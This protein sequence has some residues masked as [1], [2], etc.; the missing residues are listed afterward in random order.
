MKLNY[1]ED[2]DG[3]RAIAVLSVV[4]NHAGISLF[5]GGFIGVDVFFVISGYL[6]TTIIVRE[7]HANEFF[8]ARFYERRI[9]R[10]FPALF[11]VLTFTTLICAVIYDSTKFMTFGKS[12]I[13]TTFFVSNINFWQESGYFDISSQLKPLLHTWSLAVEEQFY[14]FFPLLMLLLNRYVR[15]AMPFILSIL[16]V[17]SLGLAMYQVSTD[18]A[19]A[20]YLPQG[21]AWELLAGALV[22]LNISTVSIKRGFSNILEI[23]GIL[24]ILIPVFVY[25]ESTQFPGLS[26]VPP[27]LGTALIILC[28]NQEKSLIGKILSLPALV[29]VGKISYSLYLWHWPLLIFGKYYAIRPLTGLETALELILIFILSSLSW[30]YVE[31]PFR[32]RSFLKTRQ[33]FAF[34]TGVM[35]MALLVG[36]AIYMKS[37]FPSREMTS[38][39]MDRDKKNDRWDFK[40]CNVNYIDNPKTIP[41]CELGVNARK[42][43]FLVW[44]DSHAPTVGK[45]INISATSSEFSGVLTYAAGCP[46]LLGMIPNPQ[47]GDVHCIDYNNMVFTYLQEHPEITTIILSSRW[48]TWVEGS[49]YKQEE[50]QDLFLMDGLEL[51]NQ[52][53]SDKVSLF[54]LG[55]ERTIEA[56]QA[57]N[58]DVFIVAPMPEIGYDVP[59]A[60]FIAS[61]TGRDLNEIIAPSTDEYLSRNKKTF[62]ILRPLADQYQI[63]IV[64]PWRILCTEV[65]CRVAVDEFPLYRDDD[66]LSTFGSEMIASAFDVIFGS[67]EQMEK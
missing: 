45:A 6:I 3:L 58:H 21:R 17:I 19:A 61:R 43:S 65:R 49:R 8:L 52:N 40:E 32:S 48:T 26:A 30:R 42:P 44:G 9:R 34:A 66:H 50:G 16:A 10:I 36:T 54:T 57:S 46:P 41:V 2:I 22:A 53:E 33:I 4:L 28:G 1:R 15:R 31:T 7:L 56:L 59:S 12:L 25:S 24:M 20:F 13:A 35:G 37:G 29:F 23:F 39:E 51:N 60:Y 11:T 47:V 63:Q 18:P 64:E 55:L 62:E 67:M 5:S 14:I 27:V 38:V